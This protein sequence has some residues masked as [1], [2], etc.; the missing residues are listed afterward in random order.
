MSW[1]EARVVGKE[2]K[3][4]R[5]EEAMDAVSLPAFEVIAGR[6][7]QLSMVSSLFL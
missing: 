1:N 4:R 6:A 3:G 7:V 5:G 2:G